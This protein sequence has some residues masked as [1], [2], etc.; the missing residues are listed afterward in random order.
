MQLNCGD[1]AR[2]GDLKAVRLLANV[3]FFG[4]PAPQ[5]A[6]ASSFTR[7]LFHTKHA[8]HSVGTLW[9]SDQF[10]TE[11]STWQHTTLTADRQ[12]WP[13]VGFE[14]TIATSER[15]QTH[16][17]DRVDT[18]TGKSVCSEY[19]LW[20]MRIKVQNG[21]GTEL[22]KI[23]ANCHA[24]AAQM[25]AQILSCTSVNYR[26]TAW[27]HRNISLSLFLSWS[28]LQAQ[29]FHSVNSI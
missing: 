23:T 8:P 19:N 12:P 14:T 3:L 29:R 18:G 22:L 5:W 1:V 15:P 4:A 21:G 7:F 2:T 24:V 17:L 13:P 10:V 28:R 16:T 6:M 20:Y 25:S 27:Q 9:T 11:T 26:Y